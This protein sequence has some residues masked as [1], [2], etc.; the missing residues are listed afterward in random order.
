MIAAT[1]TTPATI[2]DIQTCDS[3]GG[4]PRGRLRA[5]DNNLNEVVSTEKCFQCWQRF[6]MR[7]RRFDECAL[8]LRSHDFPRS[9]EEGCK[10]RLPMVVSADEVPNGREERSL[11]KGKRQWLSLV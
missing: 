8:L 1:A 6:E 9:I 4:V 11:S 5:I 2:P 3:E 10:E 7:Y